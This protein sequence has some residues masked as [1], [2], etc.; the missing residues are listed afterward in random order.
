MYTPADLQAIWLTIKLASIV[1]LILLIIATPIALWLSRSQSKL[2]PFVN[3]LVALPLIL[4]PSVIGFYL[5]VAMGTSGPLGFITH[6]LGLGTLAFSFS[7]LI[8]AS[9]IYSLPFVVQPI[10]N[11]ISSLGD[12]PFE[13][14]STLRAGPWDT[15]FSVVLPLTKTGFLTAAVLGFTH[16]VG[17]FGIVLMIGG[18]IPGVT[19]VVSVQIYEHVEA[20]DYTQAHALSALMM[21]FS[22]IVLS[23]LYSLNQHAD[24]FGT[25]RKI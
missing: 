17:E 8:I 15:F 9:V 19:Q 3:A 16:T 4:P 11:S 18:N 14:A 7:G 13:V 12:R 24:I 1:T 25:K 22:F 5:L 20:L 23:L 10:Q 21:V 2:K 6:E